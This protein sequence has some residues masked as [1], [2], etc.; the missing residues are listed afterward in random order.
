MV[1]SLV[2]ITLTTST[3]LFFPGITFEMALNSLCVDFIL[4]FSRHMYLVSFALE[5]RSRTTV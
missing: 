4:S 3:I 2:L 1:R 5:L